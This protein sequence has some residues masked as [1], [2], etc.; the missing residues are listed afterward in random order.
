MEFRVTLAQRLSDRTP[1]AVQACYRLRDG[2][3]QT[4]P[5]A[6]DPERDAVSL[7]VRSERDML[8]PDARWRSLVGHYATPPTREERRIARVRQGP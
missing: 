7:T 2:S 5:V 8:V 4:W 3:V 1:L 6:V